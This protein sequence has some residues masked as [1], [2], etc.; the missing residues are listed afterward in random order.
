MPVCL[1]TRLHQMLT[2]IERHAHT[3]RTG[4]DD[5]SI[6]LDHEA[7][8]RAV[9]AVDDDRQSGELGLERGHVLSGRLLTIGATVAFG[10]RGDL[11]VRRP[12]ARGLAYV[13]LADPEREQGAG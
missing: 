4:A 12:S 5:L 6:A 10:A 9:R 3:P 7:G 13:F 1:G 11:G 2:R 8:E